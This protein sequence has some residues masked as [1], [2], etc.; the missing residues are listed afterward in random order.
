MLWPN[1]LWV[2]ATVD[3]QWVSGPC[4]G[5]GVPYLL[6]TDVHLVP[7]LT[8]TVVGFFTCLRLSLRGLEFLLRPVRW[9]LLSREERIR[10]AFMKRAKAA[11]ADYLQP[12][13]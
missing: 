6:L 5:A 10:Q 11:S 7:L 12:Y 9:L 8:L 2:V 13:L 3:C 4:E 1:L